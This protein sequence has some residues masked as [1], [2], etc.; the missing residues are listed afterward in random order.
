MKSCEQAINSKPPSQ[1]DIDSQSKTG[2]GKTPSQRHI[3][4]ESK[5]PGSKTPSQSGIHVVSYF[6]GP[7]RIGKAGLNSG[8]TRIAVRQGD[9]QRYIGHIV[10]FLVK[11]ST[12]ARFEQASDKGIYHRFLLRIQPILLTEK[13]TCLP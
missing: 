2:R 11:Y 7:T 12:N 13:T 3:D 10:R 5:T 1:V 9:M 6:R 4:C 8:K